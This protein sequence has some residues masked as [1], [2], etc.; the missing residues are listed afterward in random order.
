[1]RVLAA[2]STLERAEGLAPV[3]RSIDGGG[4]RVNGVRVLRINPHAR[5]VI[6]LAVGNASLIARHVP[7]RDALVIGPR[8]AGGSLKR[9]AN[10]I[11]ALATR[12]HCDRDADS[13][14]VLWQR[15]DF[16]PRLAF[17][18]RLVQRGAVRS[19]WRTASTSAKTAAGT[20]RS[21]EEYVRHVERVLDVARAVRVLWPQGVLPVLAAVSRAVDAPAVVLRVTLGRGHDY[22]RIFRIDDHLVDLGG[23]LE[24]DVG[25][26][27]PGVSRFVHAVAG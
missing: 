19:L 21:R 3:G 13:S 4:D 7:P 1:M 27:F 8:Q 15:S 16:R 23:F 12:V 11:H 9:S 26:R 17:I 5:A 25:P 22:V 6:T 20:L 2:G 10:H 18:D 14:V 24:A